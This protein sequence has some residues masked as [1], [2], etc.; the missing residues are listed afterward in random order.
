MNEL[1]HTRELKWFK[2]GRTIQVSDKMQKYTYKLTA[3]HGKKFAAD[4]KPYFTPKQMLGLGIF[5]GKYMNDCIREFPRTWFFTSNS[6]T[7]NKLRKSLVISDAKS[8]N[9]PNIKLNYFK[10]KSRMSLTEWRKRGWITKSDPDVRGWFQWYCR[11]WIGRRCPTD[12]MQIKR[13]KAFKRHFA[14]VEKNDKGGNGRPRQRQALL[15][16]SWNCFI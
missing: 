5:E 10:V 16:W 15:Q 3:P 14:Q 6:L 4:F 7:K 11:Y 8:A 9:R 13:W 1:K 2:P 12:A